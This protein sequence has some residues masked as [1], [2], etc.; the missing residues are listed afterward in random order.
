V[1]R[2]VLFATACPVLLAAQGLRI[3][4]V[5]TMQLVEL[6]QLVMDSLPTSAVPGTGEWRTTTEGVPAFCTTGSGFCSFERSGARMSATP[7]LQ[8]L[9]LAAWGWREGLSVHANLRA[10]TQLGDRE[11]LLY[12]RANDHFDALDA[13][14]ELER[15]TWRGR[16]GRQWVSSGLGAY[17]FDGANALGRY[18]AFSVEGWTGRALVAGLNEPY[19]S[20]QLAAVDNLPPP[21]TGFLFGGRARYR[22]SPLLGAAA[23]Y[24]RVLLSDRSGLYSERASLDLS[25]RYVAT[26]DLGLMYD[27]STGEWNEARLRVGTGPGRTLGYSAELRHSRPVFELW[28]IWG[29]F[30]PVGFDEE[31]AMV[32]W[33]PR[34]SSFA[35][36]L[37]G[38]YRRYGETNAGL[39]LR[40]NGWRAGG[41]V[42][43]QGSD[44]LSASGSYDVD[45]GSGAAS[46]DARAGARWLAS[47]A[48]SIGAEL[49]ATQ[50]IYE[51]RIGT[52]RILGAALDGGVRVS[53]DLRLML[54]A[55]LY[56][57]IQLNGAPGP[58]W[59]QRRG[60]MRVE[61]T[62]GRDPGMPVGGAP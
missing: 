18:D 48:L 51:F 16:L 47:S 3:S 25:S 38:A 60:S 52:G 49:A 4:G 39:S 57:H 50:N 56:R 35:A 55:A 6:R 61:W 23:T 30:A 28:T 19:T 21:L 29:A 37:R 59:T 2:L 15:E 43:W 13:Y 31:R 32:S 58:D 42:T 1:R 46:T 33:T 62:V 17:A 14:V 11:G 5:T 54:D 34:G 53:P 8:D 9:T 26:V 20:A 24:Q 12:P 40:T 36:T 22:P 45:I 7:V 27:F 41:D 10:R 44:A